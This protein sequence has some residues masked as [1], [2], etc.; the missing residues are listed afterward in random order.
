MRTIPILNLK[1]QIK[2]I[3]QELNVAIRQ[4]IDKV[5][6]VFGK[7]ISDF[8]NQAAKYCKAEYAVGVSNGTDAIKLALLALGIKSGD[9][10]IC[11]AFTYYATAG[12]IAAMGAVPVFADIDSDTYNI[13]PASIEFVLRNNKRLKIKAI[14]P[15][16]L[17]G[18]CADMRAILKIAKRHRLG[19]RRYRAGFRSAIS[20]QESRDI[21]RLRVGKFFPGKKLRCLWRCRDGSD[22]QQRDGPGFKDLKEPGQQRKI[23]SFSA[24]A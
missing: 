6:F 5:S 9:G 15:V 12:A 19:Y 7:E 11:P 21:R 1:R 8:E 13:S 2:P 20:G 18:Q 22:Q 16:H 14:V 17:Y 4:V 3:R 10:V 24:R 23:F